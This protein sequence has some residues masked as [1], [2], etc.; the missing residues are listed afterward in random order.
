M[1]LNQELFQVKISTILVDSTRMQIIIAALNEEQGIACTIEE[2]KI[3]FVNPKITVVDGNSSDKTATVAKSM[4]AKV[5]QQN[6]KGKGDALN[7][8]LKFIEQNTNY[9]VV[10]DAD[11][12]Y[13]AKHILEMVDILE[14]NPQIGMVCGN[15]FNDLYP[16]KTMNHVFYIG[17][18]LIS[19]AHSFLNGIDLED[20]LTGLRVIRAD[21][22][23]EWNPVSKDF[24]IE[25]E[26]NSYVAKSGFDTV[27]IPIFYRERI[28]EKKLQMK[29]G[30][31]ILRRILTEFFRYNAPLNNKYSSL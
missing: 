11:Y 1:L 31:I 5:V 18:K 10:T 2:L 24:D 20:P 8:G 28:G 25:V 27:E 29:H 12:T 30:S 16:L 13:P 3:Y 15:R 9:V 21:L 23:R 14:Q 7:L 22:L 26:L 19:T 4:G 6:G 17:N